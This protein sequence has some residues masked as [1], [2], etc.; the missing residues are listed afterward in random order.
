MKERPDWRYALKAHWDLNPWVYTEQIEEGTP[1]MFQSLVALADCPE[2]VGGFITLPGCTRYLKTW[3]KE[4]HCPTKGWHGMR[5]EEI[6]LETKQP[7]TAEEDQ[8]LVDMFQKVP[9]RRGQMVIFDSGQLHA[10]FAN[11]SDQ[12]RLIQFIRMM[13]AT[14]FCRNRDKFSAP[15]IIK[16]YPKVFTPR[17]IEEVLPS[18]LD[19]TALKLLN[20]IPW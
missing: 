6:P 15:R 10:N 17:F 9:L 5:L 2:A 18:E 11:Y 19:P 13:P 20:I 14:E 3:C 1:R 16:D 12:L 7:L 8:K 4:R